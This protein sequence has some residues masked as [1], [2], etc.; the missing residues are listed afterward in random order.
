VE[1]RGP[2]L[3]S[4]QPVRS[5]CTKGG[6]LSLQTKHSWSGRPA[7][8][9]QHRLPAQQGAPETRWS[10]RRAPPRQREQAC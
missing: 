1:R 7:I 4:V 10:Q 6:A 5:H 9:P 3:T 8:A 2:H